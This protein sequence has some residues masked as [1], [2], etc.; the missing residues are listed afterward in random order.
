M[1]FRLTLLSITSLLLST[2]CREDIYVR[3]SESTSVDS[4]RSTG[5]DGFYLLNEGNM[6]SNKS[7]LDYFD[8]TTGI[9]TRNIYA[10]RNPS[11][12]KELGDVGNDL[13][14]YGSKLY[15]VI[16]CSHKVE[17]MRE[18]DATR[19]TKI[20]IP[21]CRYAIG[22]GG[23]VYVSSYVSPV[24]DDPTA[25]RGA[26][27]KID[28]LSLQVMDRVDVGY[29]PE[30]MAIS[31][32]KLYIAN[33]GG[34][35]APNYDRTVSVIDL[36]TFSVIKDID[37]DINLHRVKR[38]S[39][40]LIYVTSR[41]DNAYIPSRL[42]VIDPATDQVTRKID[43]PVSDLWIHGDS[44]Y[45]YSAAINDVT[46]QTTISYSILNLNTHLIDDNRIIKDGTDS[47]IKMPHGIAV[48]PVTREIYITDARNYVSSGRIHCYSPDGTLKWSQTT[49]EI[50]A[51]F[52]FRRH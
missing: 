8:E 2:S 26:V 35:R 44:A 32:G 28:T 30:E 50:P 5:I 15:A 42:Y 45:I 1:R 38:D 21:N 39:R 37:V 11:A 27:F 16:N 12:V 40:G 17:V 33:S 22:H 10:E 34:Y 23:H 52:A 46:G 18:R 14:I 36:G 7:S 48:H 4:P 25:P 43:T 47:A 19:I 9:Y 24:Q 41:G 20:D 29:Q 49:G 13:E 6:G 31:N 51:H 3:Q